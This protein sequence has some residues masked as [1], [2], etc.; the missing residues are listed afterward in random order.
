M[1]KLSSYSFFEISFL[2]KTNLAQLFS[3]LSASFHLLEAVGFW[4]YNLKGK[5][6]R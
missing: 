4:H 6:P 2:G 3:W 1:P 5:Y